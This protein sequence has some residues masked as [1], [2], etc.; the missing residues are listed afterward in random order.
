MSIESELQDLQKD[1]GPLRVKTPNLEVEMHPV[2]DLIKAQQKLK[3]RSMSMGALGFSIATAKND[4]N[5]GSSCN[6]NRSHSR[7]Q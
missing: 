3:T 2:G 7:Y 4:C 6:T 1:L 5:C